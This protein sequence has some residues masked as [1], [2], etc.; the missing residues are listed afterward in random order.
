MIKQV[1]EENREIR[2]DAFIFYR[3]TEMQ[4]TSKQTNEELLAV[5]IMHYSDCKVSLTHISL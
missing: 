3:D 5:L 2:L 1:E 4:F